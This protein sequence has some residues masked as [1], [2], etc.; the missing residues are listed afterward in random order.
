MASGIDRLCTYIHT[1]DDQTLIEELQSAILDASNGELPSSI[2]RE[3][4][5]CQVRLEVNRK[6]HVETGNKIILWLR[7]FDN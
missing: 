5:L 7:Y 2:E 3:F 6:W 1:K 4:E